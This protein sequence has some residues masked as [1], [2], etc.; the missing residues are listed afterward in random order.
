[1]IESVALVADDVKF[2]GEGVELGADGVKVLCEARLHVGPG[3]AE[4]EGGGGTGGG[5][6]RAGGSGDDGRRWWLWW[7]MLR[8]R[9]RDGEHDG[10]REQAHIHTE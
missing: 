6:G 4:E 5:G 2:C 8:E 1:L 7:T 9:E 10:R 3:C